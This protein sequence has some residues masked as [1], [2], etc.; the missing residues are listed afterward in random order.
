LPE[1]IGHIQVHSLNDEVSARHKLKMA[2][3]EH[4][5]ASDPG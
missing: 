4:T 5:W 2:I 3:L 1:G